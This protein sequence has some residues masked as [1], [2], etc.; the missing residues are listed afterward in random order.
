MNDKVKKKR[1]ARAVEQPQDKNRSEV[2]S[3]QWFP[4]HM[5]KTRRLMA[6][7][8]KLVDVV[9]EI[10]D[11]RIP[12]SSRNPELGEIIGAKPRIILLNKSDNADRQKTKLW[13]DY[14]KSQGVPA[15]C[16]DCKTGTGVNAFVPIV[17]E[18][19]AELIAR[20]DA[21]G[22]VGRSIRVM[23]VGIPNV[24]K[25]SFINRISG[26]KRAKVEDR[27]GVT[28]NKQWVALAKDVDL[29]DMPGVL[30]PK[31]DDPL[32]GEKLAF[33]GAVKD[34]VIDIEQLA[35]R[36]LSYMAEVYPECLV[37]RYSIEETEGLAGY[38]LLELV[39]KKRGMLIAGGEVNTQRAA[40]AVLDEYRC[41]KLGKITLE[42]PPKTK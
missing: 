36:F 5:A 22:M 23:V 11:A 8:L 31:F 26:A 33:T 6:D 38:E 32:V 28:M 4:G 3:I 15:L 29:L 10:T 27:P 12:Q 39:G 1:A 18:V 24:G 20:R 41:G 19:L 37:E 9:L 30:W 13:L 34:D 21:K 35:A 17:K 42:L 16:C 14:Y 25:S 40:I 7:N 2:T